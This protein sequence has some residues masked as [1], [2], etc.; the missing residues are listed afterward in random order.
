MSYPYAFQLLQ[1]RKRPRVTVFTRNPPSIVTPDN[2]QEMPS[3]YRNRST[4][5]GPAVRRKGMRGYPSRVPRAIRTRGTVDG[6]YE[7][8]ETSLIRVWC[9]NTDGMYNTNQTTCQ[10]IGAQGYQGLGM[11]FK[12]DAV[13]VTLGVGTPIGATFKVDVT[14]YGPLAEIFDSV[15]IARVTIEAWM[16][17]QS[18]AV[19]HTYNNATEVWMVD[20]KNDGFPATQ[21]INGYAHVKRILPDRPTTLSFVPNL[22]TDNVADAGSG[23]TLAP[24]GATSGYVRSDAPCSWYGA[25]AWLHLPYVGDGEHVYWLNFKVTQLRRYKR[26][27]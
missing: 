8:P 27:V 17:V 18:S 5:R 4:T 26:T 7:I 22:L 3:K 6:Y 23:T 11:Y 21:K 1:S 24:A 19:N 25:K 9:N 10:A 13:W 16:T 12:N 14:N 15:K 2:S 20:D